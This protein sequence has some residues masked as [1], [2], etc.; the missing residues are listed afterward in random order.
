MK[1]IWIALTS[2]GFFLFLFLPGKSQNPDKKQLDDIAA[3]KLTAANLDSAYNQRNVAA[4]CEIFLDDADFQ[5]ETGDLLKDRKEIE[6]H[7]TNWFKNMPPDFRHIT[8][9]QRIRFL[10]PDIVIGDGTLAIVREG[11][12][13]NEKTVFYVLLTSVG[14]KVNGQWKIAAV[15]LMLVK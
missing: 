2:I 3:I 6:Q 7:F 1:T 4:F 9:F 13:E 8:T 10:S 11:V 15:R 14:K 5:W 12:P